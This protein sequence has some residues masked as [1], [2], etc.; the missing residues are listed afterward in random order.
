MSADDEFG[1]IEEAFQ[2]QGAS[3]VFDLLMGRARE[4]GN[5]RMLFN[6]AMLRARHRMGLPLIETEQTPQLTDAQRSEY[7]AALRDAARESGELCLAGG[8]IAGAWPYFKAI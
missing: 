2:T 1:Q 5:Y 3:A 6:A 7:E 8:D 4:T